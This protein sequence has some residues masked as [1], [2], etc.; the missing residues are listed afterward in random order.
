MKNTI[1]TSGSAGWRRW[2]ML[3]V[4]ACT[5]SACADD[6]AEGKYG[7]HSKHHH[8]KQPPTWYKI[9]DKQPAN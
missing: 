4:L 1:L 6:D 3:F 2:L 7:F 8:G 9:P 5:I